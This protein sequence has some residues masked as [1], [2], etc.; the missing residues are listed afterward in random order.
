MFNSYNTLVTTTIST[1]NFCLPRWVRHIVK[2]LSRF[3]RDY[4]ETGNYLEKIF[5]FLGVRFI[6]VNDRFDSFKCTSTE[7]LIVALKNLINDIYARNISKK[8][9]SV[10]SSKQ[11]NGEHIGSIAPYGYLKSPEDKHKFIVNAETACVVQDIFN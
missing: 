6:S 7:E 3:G 9:K 8:I 11:K 5:P 10:L 1:T 4:I 2:D